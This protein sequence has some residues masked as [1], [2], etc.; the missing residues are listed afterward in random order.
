[1]GEVDAEAVAEGEAV[2]DPLAVD[3][4]EGDAPVDSEA[5]GLGL[6]VCD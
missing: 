5:V 2:P 3:E 6:A 4:A 1:V